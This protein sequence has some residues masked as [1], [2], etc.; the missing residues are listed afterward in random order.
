MPDPWDRQSD[1]AGEPEP[2]L[3]W[4][5]FRDFLRL[6]KDRSLLELANRWRDAR[7]RK[8]TDDPP[9]AWRRAA[10]RWQ[11]VERA[12]AFDLEQER[13][14]QAEWEARRRKLREEEWDVAQKL[15]ERCRQMLTV[16]PFRTSMTAVE[17]KAVTVLEPYGWQFRDVEK[18]ARAASQLARLAAGLGTGKVDV[19]LTSGG[20]PVPA[21]SS[22]VFNLASEDDEGDE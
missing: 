18:A 5:R 16:S 2:L 12:A 1:A 4:G 19:D 14:I 8:R 3:W 17:G 7:G 11:W 13:I 6:D 22:V 21:I 20:K 15:L 10:A 9:G